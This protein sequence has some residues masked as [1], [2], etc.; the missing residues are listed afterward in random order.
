MDNESRRIGARSR[1]FLL[2]AASHI[3]AEQT[4][5]PAGDVLAKVL[6]TFGEGLKPTDIRG[7]QDLQKVYDQ[8]TQRARDISRTLAGGLNLDDPSIIRMLTTVHASSVPPEAEADEPPP[9]D[10]AS[11]E[12]FLEEIFAGTASANP[13][14]DYFFDEL[15]S[16]TDDTPEVETALTSKQLAALQAYARY[17]TR[18]EKIPLQPYTR[19]DLG[20]TF[21]PSGRFDADGVD[22]NYNGQVG[23]EMIRD[24][25]ENKL[26]FVNGAPVKT[27]VE[28]KDWGFTRHQKV[29]GTIW[30]WAVRHEDGKQTRFWFNDGD[31][32][33]RFYYTMTPKGVMQTLK[34]PPTE[35]SKK[36]VKVQERL[37]PP[38]NLEAA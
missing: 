16:A 10:E 14:E 8:I 25:G 32:R 28:F 29:S 27:V 35:G 4:K 19:P 5:K 6:K 23:G 37:I 7:A 21:F 13:T 38:L 20:V 36:F 2:W 33:V 12:T 31:D 11:T 3:I 18:Q 17:L 30:I 9:S 34:K 22:W 26:L 15:P 1:R 24:C